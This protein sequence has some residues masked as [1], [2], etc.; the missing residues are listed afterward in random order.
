[1]ATD[2]KQLTD[3]RRAEMLE[4]FREDAAS[5]LPSVEEMC[6]PLEQF[7]DQLS[8]LSYQIEDLAWLYEFGHA[9]EV[10]SRAVELRDLLAGVAD[11]AGSIV[12]GS[13]HG[14]TRNQRFALRAAMRLVVESLGRGPDLADAI[15]GVDDGREH[16]VAAAA[17]NKRIE[18]DF[19]RYQEEGGTANRAA[20]WE[21]YGSDY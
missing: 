15:Q 9:D 13:V 2:I 12:A 20:W 17:L 4:Q 11:R 6:R 10:C 1:M 7:L 16:R 19:L 14:D 18:A 3:Y 8:D 21:R 5:P